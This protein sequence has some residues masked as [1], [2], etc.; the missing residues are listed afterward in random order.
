MNHT[1]QEVWG[2]TPDLWSAEATVEAVVRVLQ[3][4]VDRVIVRE[5]RLDVVSRHAIVSAL[6]SKGVASERVLLRVGPDDPVPPL[7]WA[8]HLADG[9]QRPPGERPL[10]SAAVHSPAG[11]REDV[12]FVVVAPFASPRSKRA[13]GPVLG[14]DGLRRFVSATRLPV[15]ALGGMT[16]QNAPLALAA[17]AAGIAALSSVFTE[18]EKSLTEMLRTIHQ[19]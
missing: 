14:P 12:D 7:G 19:S 4:G 5:R 3:A 16:S 6:L 9:V 11:L 8:L 1:T 15:V 17:G 2:I 10:V 13:S 18:G